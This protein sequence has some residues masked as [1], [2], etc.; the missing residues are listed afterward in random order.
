[1]SSNP[2]KVDPSVLKDNRGQALAIL[3]RVEKRLSKDE[4]EQKCFCEQFDQLVKRNT[5]RELTQED[6]DNYDG[7]VNYISIKEQFNFY[8]TDHYLQEVRTNQ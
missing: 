6:M 5:I 2:Y 3:R 7:P 8:S 1:M 4:V